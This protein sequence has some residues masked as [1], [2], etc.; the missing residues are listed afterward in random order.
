MN[1]FRSKWFNGFF[2]SLQPEDIEH[3]V[4]TNVEQVPAEL[5][6]EQAPA[7]Q[8]VEVLPTKTRF[9]GRKNFADFF[10]STTQIIDTKVWK[11][12]FMFVFALL[13]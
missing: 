2:V 10:D 7:E 9:S 3:N 12:E 6:V 13:I 1:S 11:W 4:E 8:N 5:N